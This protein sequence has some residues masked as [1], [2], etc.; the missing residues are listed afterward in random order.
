MGAERQAERR[1]EAAF[2]MAVGEVETDGGAFEE[3]ELAIHQ[4]RD[5]AI[6]VEAQIVRRFLRVLRAV[7]EA[8]LERL[9]DLFERH[10][11]RHAG[12]ARIVVERVHPVFSLPLPFRHPRRR[13]GALVASHTPARMVAMPAR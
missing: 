1:S 6:R 8:E 4:H 13:R 9:A 10:M 2:R 12:I 11:R 5:E 3:N 7:D